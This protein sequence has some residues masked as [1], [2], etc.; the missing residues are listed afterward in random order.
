M[1]SVLSQSLES[2]AQVV[3]LTNVCQMILFDL[4]ENISVSEIVIADRRGCHIG[5]LLNAIELIS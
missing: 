5:M 2:S 3:E 1:L 4:V